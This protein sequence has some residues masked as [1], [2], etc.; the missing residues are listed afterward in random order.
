MNPLTGLK[1]ILLGLSLCWLPSCA[2]YPSDMWYNK[3]KLERGKKKS[4][5]LAQ[6]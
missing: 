4:A 2:S 6:E 3:M 1:I 5:E